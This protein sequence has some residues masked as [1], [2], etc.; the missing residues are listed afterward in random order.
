MT[1]R[2][3]LLCLALFLGVAPAMAQ[4]KPIAIDGD[5]LAL[6][7][8]RIR[9]LGMDTPESY[10]PACPKEEAAGYLAAGRLQH[11][12]NTRRV[13]IVRRGKDKY[14]RTLATVAVGSDDVAQLMIREGLAEPYDGRAKRV[15]WVQRLCADGARAVPR[16]GYLP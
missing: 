10:K 13:T 14:G 6:G 4:Q 8:E 1:L 16:E 11:L 7:S 2:P 15:W 9:I 3:L 12:I 5:T